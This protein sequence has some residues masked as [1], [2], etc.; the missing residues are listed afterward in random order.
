MRRAPTVAALLLA[1]GLA[2]A[3]G[4][5]EVAAP[6]CEAGQRTALIAQSIPGAAFVP[7]V[8]TLPPGWSVDG[9]HVRRGGATFDLSSD[10]TERDVEVEFSDECEV[11]G[12]TAIAPRSDGVSTYVRVAAIDPRYAG[13]MYDAF[14]GGCVTY[15]FDFARG[16]HIELTDE[17]RD[18]IGLFPRRELRRELQDDLGVSLD[19]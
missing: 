17:L 16:P 5:P 14:P 12:A 15:R 13:E 7:C 8:A 1:S 6:R 3:C 9:Y 19:P 11:S 2:G 4:A 18:A 10:R